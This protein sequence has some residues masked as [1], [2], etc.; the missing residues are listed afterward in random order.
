MVL[1]ERLLNSLAVAAKDTIYT[2]IILFIDE[3][4]LLH[5]KDFI[6]LMDIYNNLNLLDIQ[7][8]VFM[9]RTYELN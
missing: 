1:K 6:G 2:K 3:A 4:Y 9:V 7:F 8:T 5:D